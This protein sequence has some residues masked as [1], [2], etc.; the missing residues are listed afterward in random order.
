MA[1]LDVVRDGRHV[2]TPVRLTERPPREGEAGDSTP[3]LGGR[4]AVPVVV[5]NE[6]LLGLTV[7]DLDPGFSRRLEVPDS[8][9][10][11]IVTKVDPAGASFVPAMRRG[12]IVMEVNRQAVRSVADFQRMIAAARPGETLAFYGYD[13]TQAQRTFV[14]ATVDDSR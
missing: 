14:I 3:G 1:H 12:F 7:R 13:P 8:V 2:M 6:P 5:P 10:G 9:R 11:V 4:G